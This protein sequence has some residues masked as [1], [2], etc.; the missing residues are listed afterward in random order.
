[1]QRQQYWLLQYSVG[2]TLYIFPHSWTSCPGSHQPPVH[3]F[4]SELYLLHLAATRHTHHRVLRHLWGGRRITSR[5]HPTTP[6]RPKLCHHN[7]Y[8]LANC[9]YIG[10]KIHT[11]CNQLHWVIYIFYSGLKPLTEYII[12][13]VAIQNSL[14]STP[15][16]G[17]I[18]TREYFDGLGWYVSK[19]SQVM[20]KRSLKSMGWKC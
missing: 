7:W 9:I 17:R 10:C 5:A 19:F 18:R 6:C 14:R 20:G 12:K 8:A 1:M 13:I 11:H 4:L 2:L 16:V 3:I 15:L